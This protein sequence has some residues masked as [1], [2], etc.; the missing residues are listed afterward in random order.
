MNRMRNKICT[1]AFMGLALVGF[2]SCSEDNMPPEGERLTQAELQTIMSIDEIAGI[3]DDAIADLYNGNTA[4]TP[5]AKDNDCY[6]AEYSDNG[7]VATFNNCVLNGTDDI[8]G[9]VTVSYATG[10]GSATFTATYE[11]F[12]VGTTQIN[13]TRTYSLAT[14]SE[15]DTGSFTVTIVMTV[16]FEDGSTVS[17]SGSKTVTIG[18]NE[19][20]EVLSLSIEVDWAVEHDEHT[21]AVKW[22]ED[23]EENTYFAYLTT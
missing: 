3:A 16:V 13:G 6:S 15:E 17:Y 22:V 20:D 8:N 9:T 7:F 5:V 2:Y 19:T 23:L 4:K 14:G 18:Y 12:Y 10:E 1:I 21:Y 11:D